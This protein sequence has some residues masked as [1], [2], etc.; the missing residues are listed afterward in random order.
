MRSCAEAATEIRDRKNIECVYVAQSTL[1]YVTSVI[2]DSSLDSSMELS[3]K[4]SP[5][6]LIIADK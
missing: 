3:F 1:P 5:C 6:E 4:D 2:T